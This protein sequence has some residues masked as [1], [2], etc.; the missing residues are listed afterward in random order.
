MEEKSIYFYTEENKKNINIFLP[1][2]DKLDEEQMNNSE[3]MCCV[4][5]CFDITAG[6]EGLLFYEYAEVKLM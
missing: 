2:A 5:S 1:F 4:G 3:Q 6:S